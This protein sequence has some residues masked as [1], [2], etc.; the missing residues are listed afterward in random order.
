MRRTIW[1]ILMLGLVLS[2]SAA[3]DKS[4]TPA[5]QYQALVKE[6]E[7]ASRAFRKATT[8]E[9]RKAAVENMDMF[10]RRFLDL[11][12]KYPTDPVA[13]EALTQAVRVLNS[14]DSLTQTAW[15]MNKAAFPAGSTDHSAGKA[16]ALLLRDHIGSDKLGLV[17]E[18]M[19]YGIRREYE[20]FLRQVLKASP[21]K[22][23]RGLASLSLAEF[24]DSHLLKLDLLKERPELAKRY[25]SLLGR[26]YFEELQR[27]GHAN[28][29]REIETLIEQAAT[30]YGDV[31]MPYGGTVGE[32]AEAK[33]FEIRHLAV[34]KEA[35]EIEGNDQ[36]GKQFKLS[37]Y[38]GKVV[39]L[40]FWS[41][42]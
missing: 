42:Y 7:E 18:R 36:D 4:A 8:D 14:V 24:L 2:A 1:A 37:D 35:S 13:L 17:C 23:V 31:K 21:H 25:A 6:Y 41:E 19:R 22:D 10:P 39:L 11:A 20:T 29:A 33:L 12:E 38:R 30:K 3:Q 16:I 26:E 28:L 27:K 9:E 5:K 32:Q 34:G 40:Y 15:E